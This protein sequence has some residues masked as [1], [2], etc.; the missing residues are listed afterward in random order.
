LQEV[1]KTIEYY[2]QVR[3]GLGGEF[4]AVLQD[5]LSKIKARPDGFSF[6]ETLPTSLS[7]RRLRLPQF[8]YLVVFRPSLKLIEIVAVVH[9]SRRPNY[10]LRRGE[11]SR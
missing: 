7:Y 4:A 5:S 2:D 8:P 9:T 11:E 6:V 10:W 1:E 3:P